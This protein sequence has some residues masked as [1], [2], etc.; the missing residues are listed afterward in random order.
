MKDEDYIYFA[1]E[2]YRSR[3]QREKLRFFTDPKKAIEYYDS[4]GSG[5]IWKAKLNSDEP[6]QAIHKKERDL[7]R[8]IELK[9]K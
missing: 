3:L 2:V 4:I 7:I 9:G 6:P 8:G 5:S 1:T